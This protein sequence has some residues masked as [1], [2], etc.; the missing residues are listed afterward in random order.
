MYDVIRLIKKIYYKQPPRFWLAILF[1]I[2]L[3]FMIQPIGRTMINIINPPVPTATPRPTPDVNQ[4][5]KI[6]DPALILDTYYTVL[7]YKEFDSHCT[8]L[9]ESTMGESTK[10]VVV[11]FW[12]RHY[13]LDPVTLRNFYLRDE[14]GTNYALRAGY[15]LEV[16]DQICAEPLSQSAYDTSENFSLRTGYGN[17][18]YYYAENI[19]VN[20]N[21][22]EFTFQINYSI[23]Y[24]VTGESTEGS[25]KAYVKLENPGYFADPPEI[26]LGPPT[27]IN[28]SADRTTRID[29][30][31]L[32]IY[33]VHRVAGD[34]A[35]NDYYMEVLF[36]N[37]SEDMMNINFNNDFKFA[38][39]DNYG[40]AISANLS[41]M[42]TGYN[43]SLAP[44]ETQKYYLSWRMEQKSAKLE[45]MYLRI[46]KTDAD[47]YYFIQVP[48]KE[49]MLIQPTPTPI[50]E[51]Y[52]Y[53][54]PLPGQNDNTP[55]LV[56]RTETPRECVNTL[57]PRLKPG[58]TAGVTY[59]PP[60]ANRL[61][62]NPGFR[63]S[64]I[65]TI[66]PGRTFYVMDGP[67]C[68]DNLYWYYVNFQGRYGW[69]AES[70][71]GQYWLEKRDATTYNYRY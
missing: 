25:S 41:S 50:I 20:K 66:S 58:D 43:S 62:K 1:V 53:R 28:L 32:A 35:K 17:H 19:P 39:I 27:R 31:A 29:N 37:V 40:V 57:P 5:V 69:T 47:L 11:E 63:G 68:A 16:R 59:T 61:R 67:V 70:D 24:T 9:P 45:D 64:I 46:D 33:D 60:V 54:T 4:T 52:L 55:V 14:I 71:E 23:P 6:G 18:I 10:T 65:T 30:I 49:S 7:G 8:P 3:L 38:V 56:R 12:A 36:Q 21:D 22:L 44:Q 42:N 13:G 51:E 48:F 2:A 26:L 34:N 15:D